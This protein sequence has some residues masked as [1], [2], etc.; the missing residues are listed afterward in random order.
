MYYAIHIKYIRGA[1]FICTV[2][3]QGNLKARVKLFLNLQLR[4]TIPRT[5][6]C[7]LPQ[8]DRYFVSSSDSIILR[9]F[10]C[11]SRKQSGSHELRAVVALQNVVGIA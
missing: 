8:S 9:R 6:R 1:L 3:C 11:D 4:F 7:L 10:W 2:R 5:L